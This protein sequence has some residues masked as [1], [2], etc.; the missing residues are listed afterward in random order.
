M[1][2]PIF[3]VLGDR[4][5]GKTCLMTRMAYH[6]SK[7]DGLKIYSNFHLKDI[8]YTPISFAQLAQL[9]DYLYN[10]IVLLDEIQIGADAYEIFKRSN[11]AITKFATQLRKRK[12]TLYY[13]TQVFTMATKRL[14][15]QTN[16]II[17]CNTTEHNGIFNIKTF[18]KN[19]PP[20]QQ[21]INEF[22][23]DGRPYFNMYDTDEV[24]DFGD[25]E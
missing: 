6:Y 25:E 18:D 2:Y 1:K 21:F 12:I 23:F 19:L 16:Y 3:C 20:K 11:K 13:S 22:I 24:I 4:G 17:E 8:P 7:I 10:A 9:P 14:R 5:A 15:Q